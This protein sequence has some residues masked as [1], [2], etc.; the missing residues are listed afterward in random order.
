[1]A[2]MRVRFGPAAGLAG[3]MVFAATVAAAEQRCGWYLMPSPGNLQ[4]QDRDRTWS[5]TS[6]MQAEGPDAVGAA[7]QAPD[8]DAKEFVAVG[9]GGYG[10]GCACLTVKTDAAAGRITEVTGGAIRPLSACRSD[11]ALPSPEM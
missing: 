4:L 6:Q 9:S 11:S 8:F 3:L 1:M 5:I 2:K 7:D 10:Y